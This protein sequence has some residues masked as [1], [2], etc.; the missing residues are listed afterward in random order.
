MA[1]QTMPSNCATLLLMTVVSGADSSGV[2]AG[3]LMQPAQMLPTDIRTA[4][5][6]AVRFPTAPLRAAIESNHSSGST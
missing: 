3:L 4:M 5:I 2:S 1:D 6:H